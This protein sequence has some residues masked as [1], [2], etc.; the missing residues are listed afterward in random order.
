MKR[1]NLSKLNTSLLDLVGLSKSLDL[2]V[3][4]GQQFAEP[5]MRDMVELIYQKA[6]HVAALAHKSLIDGSKSK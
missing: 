6:S 3:N 1:G 5:A 4:H 2:E